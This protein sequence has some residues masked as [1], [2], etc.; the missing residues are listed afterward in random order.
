MRSRLHK[1]PL[2]AAEQGWSRNRWI[3][4]SEGSHSLPL[5]RREEQGKKKPGRWTDGRTSGEKRVKGKQPYSGLSCP[6][7]RTVI[8]QVLR[9][10]NLLFVWYC[11]LIKNGQ[12]VSCISDFMDM[13]LLIHLLYSIESIQF[14]LFY[15]IP[16]NNL[17][18]DD[19]DFF[20][21]LIVHPDNNA[22]LLEVYL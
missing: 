22:F 16:L 2:N 6:R 21:V 3:H 20:K 15:Q 14:R 13:M 10:E 9:L 19:D 8:L 12:S 18:Y 4:H 5:R 7:L 11:P 17:I 1:S